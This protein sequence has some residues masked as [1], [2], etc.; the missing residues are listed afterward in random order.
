MDGLAHGQDALAALVEAAPQPRDA[1]P[2]LPRQL[3]PLRHL[4]HWTCQLVDCAFRS[5][6]MVSLAVQVQSF[7]FVLYF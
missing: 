4:S 2:L 5:T 1:L 6:L 3:Q 7:G